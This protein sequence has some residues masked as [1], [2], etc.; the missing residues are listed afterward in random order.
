MNWLITWVPKGAFICGAQIFHDC[1]HHLTK[2]S[3]HGDLA[4]V[5][6]VHLA[7]IMNVVYFGYVVKGDRT[8]LIIRKTSLIKRAIVVLK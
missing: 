6:C 8:E 2:Y 5:I 4:T 1:G 3:L 7:F